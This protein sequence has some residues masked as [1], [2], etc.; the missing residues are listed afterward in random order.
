ME[1]MSSDGESNPSTKS[2]KKMI[3][4]D[5]SLTTNDNPLPK[6]DLCSRT[7]VSFLIEGDDVVLNAITSMRK[8][9]PSGETESSFN[10]NGHEKQSHETTVDMLR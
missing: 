1:P 3:W 8:L 7:S 6:R 5:E 4:N 2:A 9:F 10:V